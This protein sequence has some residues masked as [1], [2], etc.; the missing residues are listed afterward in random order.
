M[1][2]LRKA[3]FAGQNGPIGILGTNA[4]NFLKM[5]ARRTTVS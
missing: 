2:I 3:E 1:K 5:M 4:F